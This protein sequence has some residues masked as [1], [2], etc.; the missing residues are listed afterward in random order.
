M[1]KPAGHLTRES[2]KAG[3]RIQVAYRPISEL[4]LDPKNP[5]AHSPR[6]VRQIAR[7]IETFGFVVPALIDA[8]GKVIAGHGRIMACLLLGRTEV[9][10]I[11]LDHLTEAQAKAFTI[12]DN[13]L[14]ENSTW[15]D[16]LLAQQL[17]DLSVEN[18]DFSLEVTGF[19]MGE[20]DMRIEGLTSSAQENKD[21]ADDLSAL[22]SG[23]AV[24][25][26]GDLWQLGEHRVYCG[27]ARYAIAYAALMQTEQAE[28]V[29]TDPPYN[30]RIDGNVSGLGSVRHRDFAMASGEMSEAE[31]KTFLTTTCSLHARHSAEG[32]LHFICMDWRHMAELLAAGREV[33]TEL[34]NLC[35]WAKD[36]A[37]MGSLYRSRHELVFVFKHGRGSHRNNIQLGQYGRNRS[38]VWNYPGVNSF[39]RSGE[40]GRL[41]A[42]HP[43]VKPVALVADAIIDCTSRRDIVLDGFLGSGTT[44]IAAQRTGR[45]CY[46]IELDPVYVDTI[47]RRW[48][49]FTRD[50]AR[51]VSSGR[52]FNEIQAEVEVEEKPCGPGK[53]EI[54]K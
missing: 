17:R 51:H 28:M 26:T 46:G 1:R 52:S 29:F 11:C 38:N 50:H 22:P 24:T 21:P 45:R 41:L 44:V 35:V 12:A 18:L 23:P 14:T 47:I 27:D 36:N 4:K 39:S 8:A 42:L 49:A 53:A 48:Q 5:R 37:G 15:N 31:F 43:T 25:R 3:L 54:T 7:S 32:A 40:E 20:I 10:T 13:R 34:K 9:P 33:Y 30:V 16:Q 6:Q 2:D 19:D